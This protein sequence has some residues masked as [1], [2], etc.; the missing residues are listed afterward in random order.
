MGIAAVICQGREGWVM[1]DSEESRL[2]AR[3]R[4]GDRDAQEAL[5][6]RYQEKVYRIAYNFLGRHEEAL[7]AC[8]EAL[9]AMLRGLA[10]YRGEAQFSTWLYHLTTRVCLMQRRKH[11]ARHRLLVE[12]PPTDDVVDTQPGPLAT[13]LSHEVQGVVREHLRRLP[14]EFRATIILRELEGL[15]YEEIAAALRVPVGTVQSRLN[16]GRKLL[17]EAFAA[18]NRITIPGSGAG[19]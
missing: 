8:Q 10:S 11:V 5:V 1:A 13:T 18:D 19:P 6:R 14:E 2:I 12:D 4:R 16:R 17:R 9:V 3:C 15:S 7:D